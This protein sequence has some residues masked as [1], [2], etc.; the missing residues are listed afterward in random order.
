MVLVT[1]FS[2]FIFDL[3]ILQLK[4][5]NH[6]SYAFSLAGRGAILSELYARVSLTFMRLQN[7]I[8]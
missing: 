6:A 5:V 7:V 2:I 3:Y 8:A 1:F 4:L